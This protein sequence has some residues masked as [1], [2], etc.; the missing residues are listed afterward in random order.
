[1]TRSV[2]AIL[3][4]EA[5]P[6]TGD[7][8]PLRRGYPALL[9]RGVATAVLFHLCVFLAWYTA[10]SFAP[11][12]PAVRPEIIVDIMS[13]PSLKDTRPQQVGPIAMPQDIGTP[14]PVD[15]ILALPTEYPTNAAIGRIYDQPWTDL[16]SGSGDEAIVLR[17][18]PAEPPGQTPPDFRTAEA[19][20]RLLSLPAPGYPEM[21]RL[22]EVEG[23]VLLQVRVG[24]DGRVEEVRVVESVP[25]LDD[26]AVRA[27]RQAIFTPALQQGRPVAVWVE[28][29]IQFRL[30]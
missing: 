22:A 6:V 23:T 8:H 4:P 16:P 2:P 7:A 27:A 29:P 19:M 26:A 15:D 24:K 12:A 9:R 30:H 14:V 17:V 25:M 10:A 5:L 21:A 13:P 28:I 3:L 1:M 11:R 18:P 20:P